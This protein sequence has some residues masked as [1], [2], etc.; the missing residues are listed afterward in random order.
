LLLLTSAAAAREPSVSGVEQSEMCDVTVVTGIRD[1]RGWDDNNNKALAVLQ[2]VRCMRYDAGDYRMQCETTA[3]MSAVPSP[4]PLPL[5][6]LLVPHFVYCRS[7]LFTSSFD[8]R[9]IFIIVSITTTHN[10]NPSISSHP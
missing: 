8:A 2:C 1:K 5:L 10:P 9:F 3:V 6:L 7:A 4:S